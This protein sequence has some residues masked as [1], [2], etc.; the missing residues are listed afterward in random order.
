[1]AADVPQHYIWLLEDYT[2]SDNPQLDYSND[3]YGPVIVGTLYPDVTI[4]SLTVTPSSPVAQEPVIYSVRVRN[5]GAAATTAPLTAAVYATSV[6]SVCGQAD[7]EATVAV[8]P[9]AAGAYV[10]LQ[11]VGSSFA[12]QGQYAAYAVADVDCTLASDANFGNNRYGPVNIW[13]GAPLQPDLVID[14]LTSYPDNPNVGQTVSYVVKVRNAGSA[15][16]TSS[17]QI[18]IFRDW[19]DA[20]PSPYCFYTPDLIALIGPLAKNASQEVT[21]TDVFGWQGWHTIHA[22]A[23][24][25]CQTEE[26]SDLNNIKG[27][28]SIQVGSAPPPTPTPT[29]TPGPTPEPR[30]LV[31]LVAA[32]GQGVQ[33]VDITDPSTPQL[34]GTLSLPGEANDVAMIE[35]AGQKYALVAAGA[36]GLQVIDVNDPASL[37]A[38]GSYDTPNN[39]V[40]VAVDDG[41]YAYLADSSAGLRIVD[42]SD[43]A[44]PVAPKTGGSFYDTTGTAYGVAIYGGY[45][46]V[47]DGSPGLVVVDVSDPVN[48][49]YVA[50]YDTPGE[51]RGVRVGP[52]PETHPGQIWA[53]VA[54]GSWGLHVVNVTDPAHPAFMSVSQTPGSAQRVAVAA[55]ST[56]G[57]GQALSFVSANDGGL[58]LV[59]P[60]V[61]GTSSQAC[62]SAGNCTTAEANA[63]ADATLAHARESN[64]LAFITMQAGAA[65]V[66]PDW[67]RTLARYAAARSAAS[68]ASASATYATNDTSGTI[69][70]FSSPP[71]VVDSAATLKVS[72][73]AHALVSSLSS[74]VVTVD[75]V[76][77]INW[78]WQPDVIASTLWSANWTPTGD[79]PHTAT[80]RATNHDGSVSEA[81]YTFIV[82]VQPPAVSI[83]PTLLLGDRYRE[84]RTLSL[85]GAVSDTAG[86][87]AVQW[88]V[89]NGAWQ[90]ATLASG[91]PGATSDTWQGDWTLEAGPPP[92][93]AVFNIAVRATDIGG[94]VTEQTEIVTVDVA[95]PGPAALEMLAGGVAVPP[96][97]AVDAS[98]GLT[99]NWSG[100]TDGS[101]LGDYTVRWTT[102]YNGAVAAETTESV[103]SAGPLT[104]TYAPTEGHKVTAYLTSQDV[105]GQQR[106]QRFGLYADGSL[107][108][109]YIWLDAPVTTDPVMQSACTRVGVD[110]RVA[111]YAQG[112]AALGTEQMLY[113]TWSADALRLSWVG[114]DWNSD[115][116]LFVYLDTAS[117]GATQLF[118]PYP[119][120][121]G[122]THITLP[123]GVS[124][125]L[126][127][128]V[129][130]D[131]EALLLRWDGSDWDLVAGLNSTQYRSTTAQSEQAGAAASLTTSLYLPFDLLGVTTPAARSLRLL[132]LASEQ[133]GLRLWATLPSSNPVNSPRV[134]DTETYVGETH[135]FNLTQA[136]AW[137]A[138]GPGV[139]PNGSNGTGTRY[140]DADVQVTLAASPAAPAYSLLGDNL[141][142]L[143]ALLLGN[144]PP[145]VATQLAFLNAGQAPVGPDQ[146]LAY[147]LTYRNLGTDTAQGVT[148][149]VT[150]Q[151]ALR[152]LAGNGATAIL[153]LGDIPAGAAGTLNF[154]A[155]VD[156][157]QSNEPW[158]GVALELHDTAH[159]ASGEPFEW[160]WISHRVDG[161]APQFFGLTQPQVVV[162]PGQTQAGG[163]AYDAS[164]VAQVSL[165]V[166][167]GTTTDCT[168]AD[169]QGGL[170]RC[171]WNVA[172]S[173]GQVLQLTLRARD[174]F[175]QENSWSRPLPLLVDAAPPTVTV[176]LGATG[177][178]PD[179]LVASSAFTVY[180]DVADAGGLG[181]VEV[182]PAIDGEPDGPCA[183]A[184][185]QLAQAAA[186]ITLGDV[187]ASA[188]PIGAGCVQRTFSVAE[189]FAV[190]EVSLGFAAQHP[191]RD[192]LRVD[193]TSPA[194][195]TVRAL[196]GSGG[197]YANYDVLLADR[198]PAGLVS[199]LG[200]HNPA[201]PF[202][203]Q[204]LRPDAP[205]I[206]FQGEPGAGAWTLRVCDT[207]LG[208]NAG[209]YL[210]SQ[211]TL[212]PRDTAAK[213]GRWT[214]SQAPDAGA[215]DYLQRSLSVYAVDVVGNRSTTPEHFSVWVDN[216]SPV[217]TVTNTLAELPLGSTTRVL[218]GTATDG[219]PTVNVTIQ[220]TAP[221]GTRTI[222]GAARDG[223]GWWYELS[224]DVAGSYSLTVVAMDMA[225]N[226]TAVGP[227]V[228]QVTCQAA[229]L[230][231]ALA[232]SEPSATSPMSIT[233]TA[234]VTNTGLA[235][236]AAGLPVVF[237]ADDQ[238]L[239]SALTTEPLG[240]NQSRLVSINWPVAGPATYVV[241]VIPAPGAAASP[242]VLCNEPQGTRRTITVV[243]RPLRAAWNLISFPVAPLPDE[244]ATALRPIAGEYRVIQSYSQG[245][246]SYYPQTPP[247]PNTLE[248]VDAL[249]GYWIRA[250]DGIS[251]TL[252]ITGDR[253]AEDAPIELAAGWNLVSYLPQ[254]SLPVTRALAAI[255]GHYLA[256]HGF[257]QGAQAFYPDLNPSFNTLS[258][259][260]P[261]HGYWIQT[262]D[263]ITLRYASAS[264][265]TAS[266]LLSRMAQAT[267]LQIGSS[268]EAPLPDQ[269]LFQLRQAEEDSDVSPTNQWINL[270]GSHV[271]VNGEPAPVGAV[272]RVFDPQGV[273]CGAFLVGV[274]SRYGV[275]PCYRDDAT[276]PDRDEGAEPGDILSFTVDGELAAA[277]PRSFNGASVPSS[278]S[279][280]WTQNL[281]R[282]EVDLAVGQPVAVTLAFFSA[283]IEPEGVRLVW[284]TVSEIDHLGFNVYRGLLP[285][286]SDQVLLTFIPAQAPGSTL[287]AAYTY[288]DTAVQV[289]QTYWYWLEDV[290]LSGATT[291][292]GPVSATVQAPTVITLV[293]LHALPASG[294][295]PPAGASAAVALLTGLALAVGAWLLRSVPDR[296]ALQRT[297]SWCVLWCGRRR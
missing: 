148:A 105:H 132:A 261:L 82:D 225:G 178:M 182:C 138:L 220:V 153:N 217:I 199:S 70:T 110:R 253:L 57:S 214:F 96:G 77:V 244:V 80:G 147:T 171:P 287:G 22:M 210:R 231:A 234:V 59:N 8:P 55:G 254:A 274:A 294:A 213:S 188:L 238:A 88:R 24:S 1:M 117:G 47:A 141:Y 180:G 27:P 288:Q 144:P 276:T 32:G 95:P 103:P 151:Y 265:P 195:T 37:Q 139:C 206:A 75:G 136:Y 258:T 29:P 89:G 35:R 52:A 228:V 216:V 158:A 84:P 23:D 156:T 289:G 165:A 172:G 273:Q 65:G 267:G 175:G 293:G 284:E 9:L 159:P 121:A 275:M 11:L 222:K 252:R 296:D 278:T 255:D 160:L 230:T 7:P 197:A 3:F 42:I 56:V 201:S 128:W 189:N 257:N 73:E 74:L 163:Y 283:Q 19:G 30:Q 119:A 16:S 207:N 46:Y 137:P 2:C 72:G 13:V 101:G 36:A 249:H 157:S 192:E 53:Y 135:E 282:W 190:A 279:V 243:D 86:V 58:R 233:L 87:A 45:A 126:L 215:L 240:P 235:T 97:S 69:V 227:Y 269:R 239:G 28:I 64:P 127:V 260:D 40:G 114:A 115:G 155:V 221:D 112:N 94:H 33:S 15:A 92:D 184:Q 245:W 202:F 20:S 179:S 146:Q 264:G 81:S 286:G 169:P 17:A 187:P 263:A 185:L 295:A 71:G 236:V 6:P 212:T 34:V 250:N 164:G 122:Q 209:S 31:A 277:G 116:D 168:L 259:L 61:A 193:L 39:A 191:Q 177:V 194:G 120:T 270:Y 106:M 66:V 200:S 271:L 91:G 4:D 174:A 173:N 68:A 205:L 41:N 14:S 291:L 140:A 256:V 224:G 247:E 124:A 266:P 241:S 60:A 78:S 102:E 262:T 149:E 167:G 109:D 292:H 208:A 107:T 251:P 123:D 242:L 85:Q 218:A 134:M 280:S 281:D 226:S 142:W 229:V 186:T 108:P 21:F 237:S 5:R 143:Q 131:Q 51:A 272:V 48:P 290:D 133:D 83:D 154:Q 67:P 76:R 198:H 183:P 99:L 203:D 100:A 118:D 268:G 219:S 63:P 12:S 10:D 129:R 248:S 232:S 62:D 26:T 204:V 90:V 50:T 18:G 130:S 98:G 111:R 162:A 176:D 297:G 145:D 246:Q 161:A 196:A 211:L 150:A 125:D 223:S 38:I 113:T 79:G 170:W 49:A 166:E 44:N 104:S 152:L 54:D 285:D 43:P 181:K 93:G 25:N